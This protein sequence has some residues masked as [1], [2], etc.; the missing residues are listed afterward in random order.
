MPPAEARPNPTRVAADWRTV[1][2]DVVGD[3]L[4]LLCV[5]SSAVS[6]DLRRKAGV[7]AVI[8]RR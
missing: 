1:D 5:A 8:Y 7:R 2:S 6:G 3:G 4:S